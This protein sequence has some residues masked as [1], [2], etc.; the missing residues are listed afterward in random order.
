MSMRDYE[1]L[2]YI[3][4]GAYGQ[5]WLVR[6][7]K[8]KRQYVVKKIELRRGKSVASVKNESEVLRAVCT[9]RH[10]NICQYVHSFLHRKQLCI[11]MKYY[12]GG[13]LQ[14]LINDRRRRG[15]PFPPDTVL[16]FL[17]QLCLG[18]K[19]IHG[20]KILHRDIKPS[21]IF[22]TKDN[23]LKIGDFGISKIMKSENSFAMTGI[24]T[25]YYLSPEKINGTPY[26]PKSDMWS[27]GCL[28]YEMCTLKVPFRGSSMA[29][30]ARHIVNDP[31]P[32]LPKKYGKFLQMVV[33][34][35][36][37]KEQARRPSAGRIL[38]TSVMRSRLLFHSTR[39]QAFITQPNPPKRPA[40]RFGRGAG[41]VEP[42]R[43]PTPTPRKP[44]RKPAVPKQRGARRKMMSAKA[45]H[46]PMCGVGGTPLKK[47]KSEKKGVNASSTPKPGNQRLRAWE[48]G[49]EEKKARD[50]SPPGEVEV[51]DGSLS[52]EDAV[53]QVLQQMQKQIEA[54]R[55]EKGAEFDPTPDTPPTPYSP[56]TPT[57]VS[58]S[59]VNNAVL[60]TP[61][62]AQQD[63]R[64]QYAEMLASKVK[65]AR[66]YL[67][68]LVGPSILYVA[69][70]LVRTLQAGKRHARAVLQMKL[71]ERLLMDKMDWTWDMKWGCAGEIVD[72]VEVER[73]L[74]SMY[75][76]SPKQ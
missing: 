69:S 2:S 31:T 54:D 39:F 7:L 3:G 46:H 36:L 19:H 48:G 62:G 50:E 30:L 34:G 47:G 51:Q 13:D 59:V 58:S 33:N 4:K 25:P 73:R 21:N 41:V 14:T 22:V 5:C 72:M 75:V 74:V 9:K 70:G 55:E 23:V 15:Q 66:G 27:L 44:K 56:P 37:T 26:G 42:N 1:E 61:V 52:S 11:V 71:I 49:L 28:I 35:L 12:E 45:P 32:Q 57:P 6:H 60:K 67:E 16:D 65:S 24:G 64:A 53:M 38:R 68:K 63:S 18:L 40:Y 10:P 76:S 20:Q 43:N 29:S 17:L 8:T